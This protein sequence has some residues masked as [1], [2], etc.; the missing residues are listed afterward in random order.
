MS[1]LSIVSPEDIACKN[2]NVLKA[3]SED[4]QIIHKDFNISCRVLLQNN[5]TRFI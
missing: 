1:L 4:Y 2:T 3:H 5:N